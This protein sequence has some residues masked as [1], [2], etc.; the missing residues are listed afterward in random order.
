M[1]I[2]DSENKGDAVAVAKKNLVFK[3]A[4]CFDKKNKIDGH[5]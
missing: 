1:V 4:F 3:M 2:W 5:S